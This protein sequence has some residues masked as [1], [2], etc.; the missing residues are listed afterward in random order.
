[1]SGDRITREFV[2]IGFMN[3]AK[4]ESGLKDSSKGGLQATKRLI[5]CWIAFE[6]FT[7]LKYNKDFVSE[8]INDFCNEFQDNYDYKTMP[9]DFKKN[10]IGLMSYSIKDMRPTHLDDNPINIQNSQD[11]RQILNIIY[12]VRC[13]LFHGG[14]SPEII[15]D[16]APLEYSSVVLFRLMEK[17]LISNG[18]LNW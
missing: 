6:A 16:I 9:D 2:I 1:M 11:L 17:I 3:E 12:R 15:S 4:A 7:C 10:L 8:R 5:Y 13:N 14:K 18:Y